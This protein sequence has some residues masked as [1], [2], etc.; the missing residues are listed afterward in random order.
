[1]DRRPV[2]CASLRPAH[3]RGLELPYAAH[4]RQGDGLGVQA[5]MRR[6]ARDV[7][8]C[9]HDDANA[10]VTAPARAR[11]MRGA[12]ARRMTLS[13]RRVWRW[14]PV[15]RRTRPTPSSDRRS[16]WRARSG[17]ARR[18]SG[19]RRSCG[20]RRPRSTPRAPMSAWSDRRPATVLGQ[21]QRGDAD[22]RRP[23]AVRPAAARVRAPRRPKA[24]R[25]PSDVMHHGTIPWTLPCTLAFPPARAR[26]PVLRCYAAARRRGGRLS[27]SAAAPSGIIG[28]DAVA[29]RARGH[30]PRPG[31]RGLVPRQR[32]PRGG[33]RGVSGWVRNRSDGSVQ[34]FL[35]GDRARSRRSSPGAARARRAPRWSASRS[36]RPSPGG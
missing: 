5:A 17:R 4:C 8:T 16:R 28:T 21:A 20:P 7:C 29:D 1:M 3:D 31:A 6:A 12:R 11:C 30:G 24:R 36:T 25:R 2:R 10:R 13:S 18:V 19:A 34:A 9:S 22:P 32:A 23:A 15:R 27:G 14:E 33:G 26:P 35:E